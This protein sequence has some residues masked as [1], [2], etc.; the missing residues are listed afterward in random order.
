VPEDPAILG[1][2][3]AMID[4]EGHI[5]MSKRG[6]KR[7]L[8]YPMVG[9]TNTDPRLIEW[10]LQFGGAAYRNRREGT[11]SPFGSVKDCFQWIVSKQTEVYAF[12]VA[13]RPFLVIKQDRADA[14][15]ADLRLR[16]NCRGGNLRGSFTPE[17]VR[18]VRAAVAGGESKASVAL[19]FGYSKRHIAWVVKEGY[20]WV[21]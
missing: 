21:V 1:Y 15:L 19:R 5:I 3:A 13:I 9:I 4:G 14:M 11:A 6:P 12:L 8:P 17:R 20:R 2:L 7:K 10:L 16:P 18:E